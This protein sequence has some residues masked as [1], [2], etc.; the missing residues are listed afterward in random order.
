[1]IGEV[2]EKKHAREI[3]ESYKR[4]KRDPGLL[5]QTDY[6]TFEMRV[7]PIAPRAEQKVQIAYY[8]ELDFDHDWATY[9]YPLATNTRAGRAAE[10]AAGKFA[11]NVDIKSEIPITAV[12]SP[13]HG[14]DFAVAKQNDSYY[15]ASLEARG[16]NLNKDVVMSFHVARPRTGIDLIASKPGKEDG[17]FALTLTA[18]EELPQINKAMDYVFVLDISGSMNDD[19][20]L[21]LSQ[22][23]L[24][25]FIAGLSPEDRFE[26]MTFNVQPTT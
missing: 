10:S 14:K 21:D 24:G 2:L 25:T 6:R 11:I 18:G 13:S 15:Q 1:M 8:Q 20:K 22:K 12:E 7:F 19:G 3:Y 9:V 5:E 4:T 23:S 16:G 26:V 17:Y